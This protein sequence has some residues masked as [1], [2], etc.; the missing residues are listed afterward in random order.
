MTKRW[1]VKR[2]HDRWGVFD[3][4]V[5]HDSFPT[6]QEA[7]TFATQCAVADVLFETGGLELLANMKA[8]SYAT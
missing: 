1:S 2:W 8:G 7:H 4:G 6:L 3:R 5:C